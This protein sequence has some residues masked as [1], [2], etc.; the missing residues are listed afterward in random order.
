[1]DYGD[2][3]DEHKN[4]RRSSRAAKLPDQRQRNNPDGCVAAGGGRPEEDS[5]ERQ[6]QEAGIALEEEH[7]EDG[8]TREKVEDA[9]GSY[10]TLPGNERGITD[11][12]DRGGQR[13]HHAAAHRANN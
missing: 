4:V 12:Q 6:E 10:V 2:R 1:M 11:H 8:R 9:V 3:G 13:R 5:L 7:Q